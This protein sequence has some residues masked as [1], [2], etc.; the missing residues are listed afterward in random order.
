[1]LGDHVI[2]RAPTGGQAGS[3]ARAGT[4]ALQS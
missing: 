2:D 4:A 1:V 3:E